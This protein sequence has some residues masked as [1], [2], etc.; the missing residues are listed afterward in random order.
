MSKEQEETA[1]SASGTTGP[2]DLVPQ[3]TQSRFTK[4]EK[5]FIVGLI[6]FVGLFRQIFFMPGFETHP[7][8]R[9]YCSP[10][11]STIYLPAIPEIVFAFHKSTELI[12]LSVRL[13]LNPLPNFPS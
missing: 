1:A 2:S 11:T 9:F 8:N 10:L 13:P 4:N 5:W 7:T 6:A 12:Y 3:P